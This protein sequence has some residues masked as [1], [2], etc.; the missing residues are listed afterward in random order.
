[1]PSTAAGAAAGSTRED[2]TRRRSL[3]VANL[4]ALVRATRAGV[5]GGAGTGSSAGGA[6]VVSSGASAGSP[7]SLRAPQDV[8]NLLAVWGL[9]CDRGLAGMGSVARAVVVNEGLRR[10]AFRNVV[11]VVEVPEKEEERKEDV[12]MEDGGGAKKELA[13]VVGGGKAS[14]RKADQSAP[15]GAESGQ[16]PDG[17]PVSKRQAKRM[18]RE[19]QKSA[20]AAA[21]DG[22]ARAT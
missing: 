9:P 22:S 21:A 13:V 17:Q 2:A 3:F 18:R 15:G 12:I 4:A 16:Q 10:H 11:R 19:A 5:S 20:A 14:K 6:L 8:V 7:L 1:M